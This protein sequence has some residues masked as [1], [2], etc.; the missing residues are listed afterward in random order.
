MA[1]KKFTQF[2]TA[3][4]TSETELSVGVKGTDN[5]KRRNYLTA[6]ANPTVN[7]DNSDGY[8]VGSMWLNT[9]TG[10]MYICTDSTVGAAKWS[11]GLGYLRLS[12]NVTQTGTNAP[13][14]AVNLNEVGA[15]FTPVYDGD[16]GYTLNWNLTVTNLSKVE[17]FGGLVNSGNIAGIRVLSDSIVLVS[18]EPGGAPQND[19]FNRTSFDFRFYPG[20]DA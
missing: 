18:Y 6:T 16:G 19:V 4:N 1:S 2:D 8:T 17:G 13:V 20:W 9:S 7:D 5:F 12:F 3:N 15:V 10:A 14:V 11:N